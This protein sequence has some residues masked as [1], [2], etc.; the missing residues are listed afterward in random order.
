MLHSL[1]WLIIVTTTSACDV[2]NQDE[3]FLVTEIEQFDD[4]ETLPSAVDDRSETQQVTESSRQRGTL[5][6]D[7][8]NCG[9]PDPSIDAAILSKAIKGSLELN[10]VSEIHAGLMM[11]IGG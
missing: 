5:V 10:L 7:T 3:A 9:I 8:F 11:I 4:S 2:S 6:I 1:L